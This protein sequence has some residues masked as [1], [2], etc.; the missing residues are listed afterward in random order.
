MPPSMQNHTYDT[1]LIDSPAPH[2]LQVTL[3]RPDAANAFNTQMATDLV[4]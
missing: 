1:L 4:H 2:I 3:N